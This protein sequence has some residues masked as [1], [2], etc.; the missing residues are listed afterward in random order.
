MRVSLGLFTV[1]SFELDH[2]SKEFAMTLD[3]FQ[4]YCLYWRSNADPISNKGC[5]YAAEEN[6]VKIS[7]YPSVVVVFVFAVL[8][9]VLFF[10]FVLLLRNN[11]AEL[12]GIPLVVFGMLVVFLFSVQWSTRVVIELA[13]LG[14]KIV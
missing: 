13:K 7:I 2:W 5:D 11:V 8:C 4:E 6:G 10:H 9:F 3:R 12:I 1:F 14:L